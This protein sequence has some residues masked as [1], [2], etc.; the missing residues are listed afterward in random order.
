MPKF[1]VEYVG[2]RKTETV[3]ASGY[4]EQKGWIVFFVSESEDLLAT[5]TEILRIKGTSIQR[6][7]R[8]AEG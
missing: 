2:A 4:F 1:S 3:E 8:L 6:I 5:K 7:E